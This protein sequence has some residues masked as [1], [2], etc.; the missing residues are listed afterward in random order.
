MIPT[1]AD[2]KLIKSLDKKKNRDSLS[3]FIVEGEK[4]VEEAEKSGI[5]II[6]KFPR[7]EIG[8]DTMSRISNLSSPPPILA[9]AAKPFSKPFET[10]QKG[11]FY[12]ALDSVKDPGNAGTII[13]LAEWFGAEA[14]FMSPDCVDIFN[15]KCI[16]SSMGSTFRMKTYIIDIKE[17]IMM[18]KKH[19]QV[20]GAF[21]DGSN[22]Y[23]TDFSNGGVV[24][25]G[26]ESHGISNETEQLI[27]NRITI[28]S[29]AN[30][31]SIDSLNVA[32][33]TAVICSEIRR[34]FA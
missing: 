8:T 26:S 33:A 12:L 18:S 14:I 17:L 6:R 24:V 16:Q 3:M 29:F 28:P 9:I 2:I 7:S 4:L 21:L 15:P 19:T 5:N 13:R 23:K 30:S 34:S 10:P 27:E 25:L 31:G 11:K 20:Y 22:I 1:K 32:M